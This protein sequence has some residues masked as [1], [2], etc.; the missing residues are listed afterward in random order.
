MNSK[1]WQ[2]WT[3]MEWNV[4]L[5]GIL[6]VIGTRKLC[7]NR[8]FNTGFGRKRKVL[9]CIL[10]LLYLVHVRL[11]SLYTVFHIS[12]PPLS[13]NVW[14]LPDGRISRRV[15]RHEEKPSKKVS[16]TVWIVSEKTSVLL[17]R[18][19]TKVLHRTSRDNIRLAGINR[20]RK[21]LLL[22]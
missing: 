16:T 6:I 14:F 1:I 19:T 2:K 10:L 20:H 9:R 21:A 17:Q 13:K 7:R 8:L 18:L 12:P 11:E 15:M 5:V 22:F 4:N 3:A